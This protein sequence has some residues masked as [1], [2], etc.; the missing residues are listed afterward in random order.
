MGKVEFLSE[1]PLFSGCSKSEIRAIADLT[2]S[3]AF[4]P[5]QVIVAQGTPGYALYL[6]TQGLVEVVC[7]GA[8]V[9]QLSEGEFFG[10]M[11]L[12]DEAPRTATVRAVENTRCLILSTWDLK[13]LLQRQPGIAL[14]LLGHLSRRLRVAQ[15]QIAASSAGCAGA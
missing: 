1:V 6:I 9:K 11:S 10:E 8:V 14:S 2:T 4:T 7:D 13:A 12:L 3:V 5:E 15:R